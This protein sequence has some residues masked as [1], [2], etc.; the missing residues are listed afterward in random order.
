MVGQ[1]SGMRGD[2][3]PGE[4]EA[5]RWPVRRAGIGEIAGHEGGRGDG[6]HQTERGD[7]RPVERGAGRWPVR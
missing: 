2:G 1:V 6:G 7:G 3:W 5:G 4:R